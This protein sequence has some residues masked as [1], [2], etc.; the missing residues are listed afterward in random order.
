MAEV[1]HF[2]RGTLMNPLEMH[3]EECAGCRLE[4]S[5][6]ALEACRA[7]KERLREMGTAY[8]RAEEAL[9]HRKRISEGEHTR[10]EAWF[11]DDGT[12][13][14]EDEHSRRLDDLERVRER[15]REA[16]AATPTSPAAGEP[17]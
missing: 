5:E 10:T 12:P 3:E 6:A 8:L 17:T 14:S 1:Q 7:E 15:F 4:K 9:D 2:Y 11:Y 13:F 16:L